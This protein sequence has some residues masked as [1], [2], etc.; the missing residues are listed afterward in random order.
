MKKLILIFS[1]LLTNSII[2]QINSDCYNNIRVKIHQSDTLSIESDKELKSISI[3]S[4]NG[5][6]HN[7]NSQ[8]NDIK[9]KIILLKPGMYFINIQYSCGQ[10]DNRTFLKSFIKQ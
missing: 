1:L 8:I 10:N 7:E 9:Y 4:S 3:Y 2:S 6:L 5:L